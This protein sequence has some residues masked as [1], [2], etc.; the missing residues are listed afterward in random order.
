MEI[1]E[2]DTVVLK[3]GRMADIMDVSSPETYVADIGSS[4]KD[5][6][7]IYITPDMIDHIVH[8][9]DGRVLNDEKT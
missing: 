1:K 8:T 7:T 4:P 6:E 3:D 2:F 9:G 5:W